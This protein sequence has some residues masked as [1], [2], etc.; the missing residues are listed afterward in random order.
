[1]KQYGD[2]KLKTKIT[3]LQAGDLVLL[4]NPEPFGKATTTYDPEPFTIQQLNGTQ[5]ILVRG[6]QVLRR[7]VSALKKC[8]ITIAQEPVVPISKPRIDGSKTITIPLGSSIVPLED[9]DLI[10]FTSETVSAPS[11]PETSPEASVERRMSTRLHKQTEFY[12]IN[13]MYG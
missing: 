2:E 8:G 5:A 3:E 4:K 9:D 13:S 11:S 12:G 7:N 1:M 6:N 10:T